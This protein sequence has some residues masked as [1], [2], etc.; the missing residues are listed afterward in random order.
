[1]LLVHTT[2][3]V[4]Y[5]G[6]INSISLSQAAEKKKVC[7]KCLVNGVHVSWMP[8]LKCAIL[9]RVGLLYHPRHR[10]N[11]NIQSQKAFHAR[12]CPPV[13]AALLGLVFRPVR[14]R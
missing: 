3:M 10:E 13:R 14:R 5:N 12:P 7:K 4:S 9:V 2:T 8:A 1:M 11:D 6:S